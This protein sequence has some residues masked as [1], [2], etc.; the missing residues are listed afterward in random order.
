MKKILSLLLAL[1]TF[2]VSAWSQSSETEG[3]ETVN[4]EA[5]QKIISDVN[6]VQLL[7]VRTPEEYAAGHLNNAVLF[8]VKDDNF[9]SLVTDALPK[10]KTV[11]V[12]C[13]SGRRSAM[14]AGKLTKAGYKVV[15]LKDGI[16]GWQQA[17]K[18]V[19]TQDT[20]VADSTG[21][22]VYEGQP[23]PDF[24]VQLTNGKTVSLSDLKGKVVML[25]FTASWCGVCRKEM[26]HIEQE[27][28]QRHKDDPNFVLIGIDYDEPIETVKKFA[29]QTG[30]TYPLGLDPKAAIF[31]K[32]SA[33]N[34]GVTR[35]VLINPQGIIIHRTR[36]YDE[37]EF[38][39]LVKHIDKVLS[40][41]N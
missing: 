3:Y 21:Y 31:N 23:C 8:N 17:G 25:Q 41:L 35:N 33:P 30:I 9:L 13:R 39:K 20:P 4:N 11:A 26:P 6:H 34:S 12:Y 2:S 18:P 22:T 16:T 24:S 7:D 32:F 38:E 1:L 10:N 37:A 19:V 27:I 14:A 15:N 29:S 40:R 5:F 36:L 28:W